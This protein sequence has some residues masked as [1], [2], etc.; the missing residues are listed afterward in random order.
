M[1]PNVHECHWFSREFIDAEMEFYL[2]EAVGTNSIDVDICTEDGRYITLALSLLHLS[3]DHDSVVMP[4]EIGWLSSLE[5]LKIDLS[6]VKANLS[7]LLLFEDKPALSPNVSTLSLFAN[8][9]YG[10]IPTQIANMKPLTYLDISTN[11]LSGTIPTILGTLTH[12]G[13]LYLQ[14]NA[15]GGSLP[16]EL[17]HLEDVHRMD[18]SSNALTS[19]LPAEINAMTSLEWL[20]IR[21]NNLEGTLTGSDL[22]ALTNLIGL[23]LQNNS[24]TGRL[25]TLITPQWAETHSHLMRYLHLASNN[26]DSTIPTEVGLM[27]NLKQLNLSHAGLTGT[28]PSQLGLLNA[29]NNQIA[30]L[31]NKFEGALPVELCP[32]ICLDV[33]SPFTIQE[34]LE[35]SLLVASNRC[36]CTLGDTYPLENVNNEIVVNVRFDE[37]PDETEW[38]LQKLLVTPRAGMVIAMDNP[39]TTSWETVDRILGVPE[40]LCE[41]VSYKHNVTSNT[42]YHFYVTDSFGDGNCCNHG[43]GAVSLTNSTIAYS[44]SDEEYNP[45][46]GTIVWNSWD[47][48]FTDFAEVYVW[49][50]SEGRTSVVNNQDG[51][52]L[53]KRAALL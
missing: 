50:D 8:N 45:Y 38:V 46:K 21:H 43:R 20:W 15:I 10:S 2:G 37:Y 48:G 24:L 4:P 40:Q 35:T 19:T 7:E 33:T 30:L 5:S 3:Q 17:G 13:E 22:G 36:D 29:T 49:V 28:I 27:T 25:D 14:S 39:A 51:F 44:K 16:T 23:Y 1:E 34:F 26:F 6:N 18:L 47:A 9:I 12:L 11:K 31:G 53:A 41:L 32:W 52:A 42:L